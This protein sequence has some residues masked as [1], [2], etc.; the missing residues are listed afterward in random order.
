VCGKNFIPA[1]EHSYK[2]MFG[3]VR[4][5]VCSNHCRNVAEA[6]HEAELKQKHRIHKRWEKQ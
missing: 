6:A 2:A 3:K 1:C 4:K 5:L